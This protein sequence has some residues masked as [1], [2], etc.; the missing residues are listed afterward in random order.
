MTYHKVVRRDANAELIKT[1]LERFGFVVIDESQGTAQLDLFAY[2][3]RQLHVWYFIEVKNP[4]DAHKIKLT[5]REAKFIL[6][7]PEQSRMIESVGEVQLLA[8]GK[9]PNT[10]AIYEARQRLTKI[11]KKTLSKFWQAPRF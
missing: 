8:M 7:H 4:D 6:A 1:A 5:E 11:E 10:K 3:P 9:L 2:K